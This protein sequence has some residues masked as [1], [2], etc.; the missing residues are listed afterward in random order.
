MSSRVADELGTGSSFNKARGISARRQAVAATTGV[1]TAGA[2]D[3]RLKT[4]PLEQL[5]PT[6]FNPRRNFGAEEDLL[7]FGLKLKKKQLQ[8]A[9]A[10]PR[11]AYLKLWPDE[12]ASL[13]SAKYVISNGE[14]RYR[15]SLAAGLTTLEVV[16]DD[17]IAVSRADFLDAVLSENN[18]REDLD[19][20]ERALGIKTMV[21]QLGGK[22]KVAEHYGKSPGWVTQQMY[23]LDLAPEL[24]QLVSSGE[25]PV[26]ETRALVKLPEADQ[27]SAWQARAAA[28]EEERALPRSPRRIEG[29]PPRPAATSGPAEPAETFTAVKNDQHPTPAPTPQPAPEPPLGTAPTAQAF[30]AVKPNSAASKPDSVQA[31]PDPTPPVLPEPRHTEQGLEAPLPSGRTLP[32]HDGP[33]LGQH[34]ALKMDDKPY[35]LMLHVL[36]EKAVEKDPQALDRLLA[37][38]AASAL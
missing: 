24:Q 31:Q 12:E 19:P 7:E 9:V 2:P 23:L 33:I 6:R 1:P 38:V 13:G 26:R 34:L 27:V 20:I 15:G 25:L 28:R 32:Y 14:R 36:L 29:G 8:P 11:D 4:L 35:F 21:E 3:S 22:A 17:D 37:Q 30:T 5:V 10:V 16:V 18:D